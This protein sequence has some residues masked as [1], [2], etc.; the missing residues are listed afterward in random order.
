MS[1]TVEEMK[2][3]GLFRAHLQNPPQIFPS[4]HRVRSKGQFAGAGKPTTAI[5]KNRNHISDAGKCV[6][7]LHKRGA[8]SETDGWG[9]RKRMSHG[10][11]YTETS[12]LVHPTS[13]PGRHTL[14]KPHRQTH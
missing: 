9:E 5:P 10:D 4:R 8:D 13:T 11:R 3:R 7:V 14:E 12:W 2:I 1:R 6:T